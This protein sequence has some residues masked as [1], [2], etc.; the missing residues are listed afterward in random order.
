MLSERAINTAV[1]PVRLCEEEAASPAGEGDSGR[2]GGCR[3]LC[4]LGAWGGSSSC[5][6]LSVLGMGCSGGALLLCIRLDLALVFLESRVWGGR[7]R[8]LGRVRSVRGIQ[9]E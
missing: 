5:T 4:V 2:P 7:G 8:M 3:Q 1:L 9:R 6:P